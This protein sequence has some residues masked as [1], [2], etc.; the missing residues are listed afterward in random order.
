MPVIRFDEA[1]AQTD[2]V[3]RHIL[4][5]NGFGIALFSNRFRYG[6]LLDA[7]D[8]TRFPEARSAFDALGT[9]DFEIVIQSPRHAV[10][11]LPS[12]AATIWPG[13]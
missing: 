4:L 13:S 11:H 9:T 1:L 6:S 7:V 8:F 12:M 3:K 5:G 2:N 10:T